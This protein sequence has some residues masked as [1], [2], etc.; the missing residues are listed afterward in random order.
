[1]RV[2]KKERLKNVLMYVT[3]VAAPVLCFY[4]MEFMLRNPFEKMKFPLQ[5]LNILFFELFTLF[6]VF[7]TGK[8]RTAVRITVVCS[9][10]IGL[11][12]Y[13]IVS[14]RGLPV[15]PWDLFSLKTAANV[16]DN[17]K[18]RLTP[19]V[20]FL[21]ICLIALFFF[22]R[23]FKEKISMAAAVRVIAA[24]FCGAALIVATNYV[25]SPGAV[26][27]FHIYDKLFTPLTMT[28][29]DGTVVA[30]LMESQYLSVDKPEGYQEDEVETLLT[31]YETEEPVTK[32][33]N[34]IVIM[35]E[36]FSDLSI[37]GDYE[38]NEEVMPF[39]KSLMTEDEHTISGYLDVS[40]LGGNTANTEFEFLTGDSMAFLP[41]GCIPYQQYVKNE[42]DSM[43]SYLKDLGYYCVAM[44]PFKAAG[45]DR[46][47]VY[48]RF[49][50]E[51]FYSQDDFPD[52]PVIRKYI[53]DEAD[54]D[55]IIEIFE[56]KEKDVPLFL[57]NVTMQNHSSY[58]DLYDNFTP[59]IDVAD[60]DDVGLEQ[61]LSLV[62]ESDRALSKLVE[63]FDSCGED[64]VIVHFG[65]HQPADSVARPIYKL[66]GKDMS[67]LSEEE[68][69]LRYKVPYVI[70]ANFDLEAEREKDSSANFLGMETL[71][72]AGL[73]LSPYQN[74]L[75]DLKKEF[76][77]VSVMQTTTAD[78]VT[79][80]IS[81]TKDRL[82]TYQQLQYYHL[83]DS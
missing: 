51:R 21:L 68:L 30:F 2:M 42:T 57:F 66:N 37:L 28:Y 44:H 15:Q 47:K 48:D 70:H 76:R 1:M 72:A 24:V 83:F 18:Y 52:A 19:K 50:F 33:P 36:A 9:I 79:E 41:Q 78:G 13:F 81:E 16:A 64:T 14:F 32:R 6:W 4:L 5:L 61:Y 59:M 73:P 35:N 45:W 77:S 39:V 63:Y 46:D 80:S 53:S 82:N 11:V 27:D 40:V 75:L 38:T 25:Q 20:V 65:D 17:Y 56:E 71:K 12:N 69:R 26:K 3:L 49:G 29:K 23:L 62:H 43:A 8:V 60:V 22:C 67:S 74:Y 58:T 54:Y 7:V 55:K 31:E 10:V 34:V